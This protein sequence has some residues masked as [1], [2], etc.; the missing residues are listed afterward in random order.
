[1][2]ARWVAE[3]KSLGSGQVRSVVVGLCSWV[4]KAGKG[5]FWVGL[6]GLLKGG[7]WYL[8]LQCSCLW[9]ELRLTP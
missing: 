5:L 3:Y 2:A 1:M 7:C 6:I 9:E 4:G 8:L